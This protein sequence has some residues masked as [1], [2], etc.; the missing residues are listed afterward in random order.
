MTSPAQP[1]QLDELRA[2]IADLKLVSEAKAVDTLLAAGRFDTERASA[3]TRDAADMIAGIRA[4]K[5]TPLMDAFLKEYGLNDDEGIALMCLAE[6]LLRTPHGPTQDL[7]IDDKIAHGNWSDHLGHS[8]SLLVNLSSQGLALSRR[9]LSDGMAETLR[10]V[11]LRVGDV[12]LRK[13]AVRAVTLLAGEFVMGET[14]EAA[15]SRG[16]SLYGD[17]AIFSFDMLGE[18]ARTWQQADEYLAAYAH[19]IE[20]VGRTGSKN[21]DPRQRNGVSIKLS[22]L[23]PRYQPHKFDQVVDELYKRVNTLARAAAEHDIALNIDAEEADRL[24]LSLSLF[25]RL[26]ANAAPGWQG[27]GFVVQAYGKR[28]LA[29]I[30]WLAELGRLHNRRIAVRLVKGAY[31]DSEIKHAQQLGLGDYPVFTRKCNTDLSYLCCARQIL[32]N[33]EY[34]YGQFA[35]HNAHT[36]LAVRDLAGDTPYELQRLHGM[37][38]LVYDAFE[39]RFDDLPA[40]RTYAPVGSHED[41]LAYLVRRLL[42]NGASSSFVH[43]LLDPAVELAEV[44]GDPIA[45]ARGNPEA[46]HP[47]IPLPVD[48][49]APRVNALGLDLASDSGEAEIL[50]GV[51]LAR[52]H[53]SQHAME[54]KE[55]TD[56]T[57][58]KAVAEARHAQRA[59]NLRGG[60]ARG[61]CLLDAADLLQARLAEFSGLLIL[62]AGKTRDDA[63]AEVREAIDFLRYYAE[64][65]IR[66]FD[67]PES[68]PGPTGETNDLYLSGRGVFVCISPWNFPLAIFL[69]QVSAALAAGNAVLAKPA[70]QTPVV[71]HHAAALLEMAGMPLQLLHVMQGDARIGEALISHPGVDG[72]AFTGSNATAASIYRALASRPGPILPFIAETGGQNAMLVDATA[73]LEQVVDDVVKSAFL[74]AGQRCSALRVLYVQEEIADKTLDM[75][76]GAIDTLDVADPTQRG[77]DIGPIIDADALQRLRAHLQTAQVLHAGKAPIEGH[78]LAPHI[79]QIDSISALEKEHFGPIL[80]V[81]RYQAKHL[82]KVLEEIFATGYGLTLGVHTRIEQRWREIAERAPIGNVYVNRDMVGAVVGSQPFGGQGLSGTG[83]KAGGP[84]Y[85]YRFA[86]ERTVTVNTMATGGSAE[87]LNLD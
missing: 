34:L 56:E 23:H 40:V 8:E 69:G 78:F 53:L 80:H 54:M 20:T 81:V 64:Q 76:I 70:P 49:F 35:S 84:R 30:D 65:A 4:G 10:R 9:Y 50:K 46:R 6:A 27:L 3:W 39:A 28:A 85:L 72:V 7:L 47:D 62:E 41:L 16:A 42:E 22:A 36:L 77:T 60:A 55:T 19:A 58:N 44:A 74:S 68:L 15:M 45:E 12:V 26:V 14:I 59:W 29:V 2:R 33:N 25:E 37:G 32:D 51:E 82:S 48:L 71:A 79:V 1:P 43:Q 5:H 73:Q 11:S 66:E 38:E 18:G 87:L 86:T 67:A 31:W 57:L 21:K 24:E 17:E 61:K 52:Q 75:L 13:A 83:F 63:V